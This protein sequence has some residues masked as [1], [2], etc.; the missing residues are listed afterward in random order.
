MIVRRGLVHPH[1]LHSADHPD[2]TPDRA[3]KHSCVVSEGIFP[4]LL[5]PVPWPR[6]ICR[7]K[8]GGRCPGRGDRRGRPRGRGSPPGGV[9]P[10]LTGTPQ[11]TTRGSLGICCAT[12]RIHARSMRRFTWR[13]PAP[14]RRRCPGDGGGG[15]P[16][17]PALPTP[18]AAAS[19]PGRHWPTVWPMRSEFLPGL[20]QA[21]H[22]TQPNWCSA[23][24]SPA[25]G[26]RTYCMALVSP[27]TT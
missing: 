8:G 15:P 19:T 4:P 10:P 27:A 12:A 7:R 9:R 5:V 14:S 24:D 3:G 1:P 6:P 23:Y 13:P 18:S 25:A 22:A 2:G 16:K 20:R 17:F 11:S 21:A 26:N